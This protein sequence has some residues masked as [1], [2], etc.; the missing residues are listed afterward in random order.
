[1]SNQN[2]FEWVKQNID[3]NDLMKMIMDN[4]PDFKNKFTLYLLSSNNECTADPK[5]KEK[6]RTI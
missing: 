5:T 3:E 1:M 4:T 2:I 6:N